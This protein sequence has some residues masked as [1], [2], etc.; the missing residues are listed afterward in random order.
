VAAQEALERSYWN[1]PGR[2]TAAPAAAPP[3]AASP[4]RKNTPID[5]RALAEAIG[6]L[7]DRIGPDQL[8]GLLRETRRLAERHFLARA[9][10]RAGSVDALA[11]SLGTSRRS[12]TRRKRR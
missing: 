7:L 3:G 12:L 10:Q 5:D 8:P 1:M 4:A 11:R 6:R 9:L 2:Q